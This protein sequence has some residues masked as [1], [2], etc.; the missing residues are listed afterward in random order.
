M[1]KTILYVHPSNELYGADRS[2]LRL[3]Q[4]L[5]RAEFSPVVAIANDVPYEGLLTAQLTDLDVP[6]V[7][8]KLGV[9][10]RRYLSLVGLMVFAYQTVTAAWHL[11][12][13]CRRHDVALIHTNSLAVLSG[14]LAAW[15]TRTPHVWHVREIITSGWLNWFLTLALNLFATRVVV[16]SGPV[17]RHLVAAQPRLASKTMVIHNGIDVAR[18]M[19]DDTAV[20]QALRDE[21]QI[22]PG[23]LIVGMVGRISAWKGQEFLL[24]ATCPILRQRD[25]VILVFVGGDVPGETTHQDALTQMIKTYGMTDKVRLV[26]F[27]SNIPPILAAF[28]VFVLPSTRPDPFPT[29]VLEAMAAG[30]PVIATAHGGSLEQVQ[31]N[32]TGL[33]VSPVDTTEM[34]QALAQLLNPTYPRRDMGQAGRQYALTHFVT[35]RY[36]ADVVGVYRILLRIGG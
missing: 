32:E 22:P 35:A 7:Q 3:V 2:L 30:K 5:D 12:R 27:Q 23:A 34:T 16:V 24:Q 9:L 14:G 31:H 36:V 33:L 15:L 13:Y 25:D 1:T 21:W 26:G 28:D 11:A 20:A 4:N 6:Y 29:V 17:Q 10:R 18:F 19:D 8:L